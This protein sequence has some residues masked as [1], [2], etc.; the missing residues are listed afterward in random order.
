MTRPQIRLLGVL[1]GMAPT[2]K[3]V[4]LLLSAFSAD[5]FTSATFV[6]GITSDG[7]SSSWHCGS[8]GMLDGS[9]WLKLVSE[10]GCAG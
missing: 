2:V 10:E 4:C 5:S 6:L 7:C 8:C 3:L 1:L 9:W